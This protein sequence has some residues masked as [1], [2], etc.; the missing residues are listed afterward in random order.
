MKFL[1][2]GLVAAA[3]AVGGCASGGRC[4]GEFE[5]QKAQTLEPIRGTDGVKAPESGSAL[6]I[7]PAPAQPV[8]FAQ[9]MADPDK[10][11]KEK[12]MCLDVPPPMPAP[13]QPAPVE[14]VPA[15]AGS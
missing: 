15:A 1:H 12:I 13:A 14:P 3:L 4:A 6:K 2:L 11:G 7:P 10:P 5:Y 8:P 9:R